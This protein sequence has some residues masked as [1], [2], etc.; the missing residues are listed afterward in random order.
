MDMLRSVRNGRPHPREVPA[1]RC[2]RF[3]A[4][5]D[6]GRKESRSAAYR[7]PRR[8]ASLAEQGVMRVVN[9]R[10]R[11]QRRWSWDLAAERPAFGAGRVAPHPPTQDHCLRQRPAVDRRSARVYFLASLNPSQG[12]PVPTLT[13]RLASPCHRR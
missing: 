4:Q 8:V 1:P 6:G 7:R 12:Q 13:A 2:R 10:P 3:V 9:C 5:L 11:M